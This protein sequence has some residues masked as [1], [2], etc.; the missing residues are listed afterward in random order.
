M[1]IAVSSTVPWRSV[2]RMTYLGESLQHD[3]AQLLGIDDRHGAPVIAGHVV[4]D[5]NRR[6]LDGPLALDL[7]DDLAQMLFEIVA[8][9]DRQR[10]IID[11]R[12]VRDDHQN[13]AFLGPPQQPVMSPGEGLAVD[14]LLQDR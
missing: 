13:L 11:R 2:S 7:A 6:Q 4:A 5:A 1:P 9:I 3:A 10:R 14:I 8:G 12:A